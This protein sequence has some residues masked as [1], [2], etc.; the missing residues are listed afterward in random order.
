[1]IGSEQLV[2][3]PEAGHMIAKSYKCSS[4]EITIVSG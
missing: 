1:M 4:A 2:G 3:H